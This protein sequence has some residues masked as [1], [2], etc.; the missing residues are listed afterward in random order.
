MAVPKGVYFWP[1]AAQVLPERP[2]SL[3]RDRGQVADFEPQRRGA[4]VESAGALRCMMNWRLDFKSL[5]G[6]TLL[7]CC[8]AGRVPAVQWL[9]PICVL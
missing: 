7:V 9:T 4:L 5:P 8:G 2:C 6:L 1:V 3:D